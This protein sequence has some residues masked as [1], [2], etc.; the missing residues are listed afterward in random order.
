MKGH[1]NMVGNQEEEFEKKAILAIGVAIG[2][3]GTLV[4]IGKAIF[5][6]VKKAHE[7]GTN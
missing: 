5:E 1:T 6:Q 7:D 4:G 2:M 3:L